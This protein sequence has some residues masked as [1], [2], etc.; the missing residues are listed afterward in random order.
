MPCL[1]NLAYVHYTS[2]RNIAHL[3]SPY[4]VLELN[5]PVHHRCGNNH[6]P[7]QCTAAERLH[8]TT[9]IWCIKCSHDFTMAFWLLLSLSHLYIFY[10]CAVWSF[11]SH[12][13]KHLGGCINTYLFA[14]NLVFTMT[15]MYPSLVIMCTCYKHFCNLF[16]QQVIVVILVNVHTVFFL[17]CCLLCC[18]FM[19][20][21][22][23][24]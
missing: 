2:Y 9:I 20:I 14:T 10:G 7:V 24:L 15:R 13:I 22:S 21:I 3:S 4:I 12:A 18:N 16:V 11:E 5:V 19:V 6:S 8:H 1:I 23:M 17:D